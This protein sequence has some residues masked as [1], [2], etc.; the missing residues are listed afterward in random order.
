MISERILCVCSGLKA[1]GHLMSRYC[2]SVADQIELRYLMLKIRD[3]YALFW[4]SQ[5][6]F[7]GG[8][9]RCQGQQKSFYL[10]NFERPKA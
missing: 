10:L 8:E 5:P 6:F 7:S 2:H 4:R 3:F 9:R 1:E